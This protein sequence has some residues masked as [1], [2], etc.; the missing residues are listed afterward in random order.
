M[1][2]ETNPLQPGTLDLICPEIRFWRK[3]ITEDPRIGQI[4]HWPDTLIIPVENRHTAILGTGQGL[5]Q[6]GLGLGNPFHCAQTLQM[7]R[8]N[9]GDN[10]NLGPGQGAEGADL[11]EIIHAHLEHSPF[12]LP[13]EAQQGEG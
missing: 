13:I 5:D 4:S 9:I 6:F 8:A 1:E 10:A 11:A 3:P 2:T 12:M 7:A